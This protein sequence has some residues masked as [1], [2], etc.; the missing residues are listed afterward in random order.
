MANKKISDLSAA[1]A[2][3]GTDIVEI[4]TAAGVSKKQ[5]LSGIWSYFSTL[6]GG[7]SGTSFP[8]SPSTGDRFSRTDRNIDY[9]YDG[10]RWLSTEI[11]TAGFA[12]GTGGIS[13]DTNLVFN[14]PYLPTYDCYLIAWDTSYTRTAPGEWDLILSSLDSAGTLATIDTQD[15]SA[16]ATSTWINR[17]RSLTTLL[18]SS[19]KALRVAADEVS[20]T[21][22]IIHAASVQYRLVG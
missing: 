11:F 14:I 3:V 6:A 1:G 20:G 8:V 18:T 4:E 7:S 15:G 21:A 17:S 2:A 12:Q 9:F 19:T 5:T 10:T 22:L 13:V 16:D